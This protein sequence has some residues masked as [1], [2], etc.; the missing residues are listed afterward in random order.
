M[1]MMVPDWLVWGLAIYGALSLVKA[2]V[3]LMGW[4]KIQW[5]KPGYF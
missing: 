3:V 5:N 2:I 4:L 1:T